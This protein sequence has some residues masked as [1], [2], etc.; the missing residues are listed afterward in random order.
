MIYSQSTMNGV[1]VTVYCDWCGIVGLDKDF[2]DKELI[3]SETPINIL[4]EELIQ[5]RLLNMQWVRDR[6]GRLYCGTCRH[7]TGEDLEE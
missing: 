5:Q 3:S 6:E 2:T 7:Y 1:Q 4:V